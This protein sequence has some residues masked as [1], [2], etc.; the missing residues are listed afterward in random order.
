MLFNNVEYGTGATYW[1]ASRGV[2]AYSDHAGFGP[3]LVREGDGV[4]FA[5][6]NSMFY[7]YGYEHGG[8]AAVR[9][10]VVLKSEVSTDEVYK[11]DDQTEETWSYDILPPKQWL[12]LYKVNI[13]S[14]CSFG[15]NCL[16]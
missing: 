9:P 12:S 7:S 15:S 8:W 3:G 14:F 13:K 10:V 1:L 16:Q 6:T 4:T 2:H 11:I 5:G